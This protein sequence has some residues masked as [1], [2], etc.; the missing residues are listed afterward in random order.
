MLIKFWRLFLRVLNLAALF[1]YFCYKIIMSGWIVGWAVLRGYR[2][3]NG[4]MLEYKPAVRSGWALV[5]LFS[6]IS[7]TPGSLSVDLSEDNSVIQVHLLDRSGV[8]DFLAVTGRI[9]RMLNRI[10]T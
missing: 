10:F 3:E 1:L 8:D 6:L 5:L 7:M 9:E 4:T 2:G